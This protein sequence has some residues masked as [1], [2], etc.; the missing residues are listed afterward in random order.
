[1]ASEKSYTKRTLVIAFEGCSKDAIALLRRPYIA[2]NNKLKRPI[3]NQN[4]IIISHKTVTNGHVYSP[5]HALKCMK[6]SARYIVQLNP[7]DLDMIFVW[8]YDACVCVCLNPN[9]ASLRHC[10]EWIRLVWKRMCEMCVRSVIAVWLKSFQQHTTYS[11]H[12][13]ANARVC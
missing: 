6:S 3:K 11:L 4:T 5:S 1:M 13:F 8:L 12:P 7:G 9:D 2:L 10:L